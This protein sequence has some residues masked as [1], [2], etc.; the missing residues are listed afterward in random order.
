[1]H[2]M[3][4]AH[5]IT[6]MV[7]GGTERNVAHMVDW[8][9]RAG[10]EVTV[11]TGADP[12]TAVLAD[13][14]EVR[15]V[16]DLVR[17]VTAHRD[18]AALWH[19]RRAFGGQR[20]DVVHTHQS[21]AGIIGRLAARPDSQ[22]VVH[23]VHMPSFG[24]SY[25]RMSSVLLAAERYCGQR[26]DVLVTVG[27]DLRRQY[28]AA[29]VGRPDKYVVLRSPIAVEHLLRL[30]TLTADER[31]ARRAALQI[32]PDRPTLVAVG[33]LEPRKRHD[34]LLSAVGPLLADGTVNVLI[35][36]DGPRREQLEA[37]IADT[38]GG[39]AVRMLGHV[40]PLDDVLAAADLLV[41]TSTTE[42]VPQTVVQALAAGVP[43]VA[44]LTPGLD[45][46]AADAVVVA[47]PDGADLTDAITS[48]LARPAALPGA[49]AF[50]PWTRPF[51]EE[52]I[53]AL[54]STLAD[55]ID[56]KRATH[57]AGRS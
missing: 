53:A 5:V 29:G 56:G 28:I 9:Q 57:A 24:P 11:F 49:R 10:H 35:A 4:I 8:Q 25:G 21:K 19:L 52:R 2:S 26:T 31:R 45:E 32:D 30:R 50:T 1:M 48:A 16:P 38:A 40:E 12:E 46:V 37:A 15:E 42:G 34:L 36:G 47:R 39:H 3:K 23:T 41:Q 6:R 13:G 20:F 17:A 7:R 44:T 54:H 14:V 43:V 51:I 27:D 18:A 22:A 55:I 33:A